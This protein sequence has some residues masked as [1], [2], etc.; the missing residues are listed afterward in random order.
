[1]FDLEM[2]LSGQNREA[3]ESQK[4]AILAFAEQKYGEFLTAL[5]YDWENDPNMKE[6]PLRVAKMYV[7]EISQGS[8]NAMPHITSF[9][10]SSGYSGMVFEG[11]IEVKSICSHH[12]M[13]FFGK[14]YVAY[15]P[16]EQMIG[17]SKLN[18]VVEHYS[19]RPQLQEQLTKQIHDELD[20]LLVGN[21]GVAVMINATHTCVSLRGA[22]QDSHM[23]TAQLSGVFIEPMNH[24]RTE[25]YSLIK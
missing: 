21:K 6:T 3:T 13:P 8:Y 18:R 7:K 23:K 1:M 20:R 10:N 4:E 22:N 12:M 25:F 19:R 16:G 15:I 11:N 17:L 9:P 14:A 5:G 2:I 24:V